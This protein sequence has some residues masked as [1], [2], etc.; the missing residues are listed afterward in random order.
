[1]LI[2]CFLF[3]FLQDE[4]KKKL[5]EKEKVVLEKR[6]ELPDNPHVIV[7]PNRIAKSGKFDCTTMSLSLLLDYRQDDTKV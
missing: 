1:M 6:Y 2:T 4:E 5:V 3:L 7:H